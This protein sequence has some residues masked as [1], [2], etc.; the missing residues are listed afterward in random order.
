MDELKVK[1]Y[2]SNII[3]YTFPSPPL[4]NFPRLALMAGWEIYVHILL[5]RFQTNVIVILERI[6]QS[7][8]RL[9]LRAELALG[10]F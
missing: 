4:Q 1:Y 7:H 9:G 3:I 5:F 2:S 8:Q 10:C 6:N